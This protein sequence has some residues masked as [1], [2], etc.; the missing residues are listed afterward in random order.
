MW[1]TVL[2]FAAVIYAAVIVVFVMWELLVWADLLLFSSLL[3]LALFVF[4]HYNGTDGVFSQSADSVVCIW[5]ILMSE[6][7]S[8]Y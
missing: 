2:L 8:V 5:S 6:V 7:K 4:V 1:I 3:W